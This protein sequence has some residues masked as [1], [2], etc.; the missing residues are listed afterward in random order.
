MLHVDTDIPR[1]DAAVA[2]PSPNLDSPVPR[3]DTVSV[4]NAVTSKLLRVPKQILLATAR[5]KLSVTSGHSVSVRALLDQGSEAT[6]I[7]E[8][9]A[10]LLRAK[11]Q[12]AHI[13][14][15]A[16]GGIQL[17]QVRQATTIAVSPL[18]SDSPSFTVTA[19]I[20]RSLTHYAPRRVT[21]LSEISHLSDLSWADPDPL[22]SDP[23]HVILGADLYGDLILDG[24]R[25]GL[26]GQPVAQ[27]SVFG[28]LISGP[29][30]APLAASD[31]SA[32]LTTHHCMSLAPLEEAIVKFWEVEDLPAARV[33]TQQ[34]EQCE[35]HFCTTHSRTSDGRYIVRLPFNV[36]LPLNLGPTRH[37]AGMQ[38]LQLQ[39]RFDTHPSLRAEYFQ[40]MTEYENL[41]HMRKVR[42]SQG[43]SQRVFIPHHPVIRADSATTRLRVVFNASSRSASGLSLNDFL[44]AGPKLQTELPAI[45]LQWRQ[46]RFVYT[47]D[48]AKMFRQILIDERDLDYQC[49]LW[50]G[51]TS[52]SID[53]YQL[54][55]VTYGMKC[56]PYLALRV[57]RRLAE[58]D[59]NRFPLAASILRRQIYVDDVLFGDHD[60]ASLK[61]KRD[62]LV[63]L[64][65]CGQFT[66]RKWASNSTALLE[67]I[68]P[69]DHGLACDK[70]LATDGTVKILG[71]VWNPNSD[72]FSYRVS[73]DREVSLTKRSVLS[74]IARLYDPLGWATPVIIAAKILM[75][76]LWR[77]QL[78]WDSPLPPHFV[79]RWHP[80][81]TSFQFLNSVHI[82]RWTSFGPSSSL[83][84]H[85]FADASTLAYAAAV[86]ARVT[87][88]DGETR[89]ILLAGKSKVAP[90]K[91]LTVPRLELLAALLLSRLMSFVK[92][93]L[94]LSGVSCF[95]WSDSTITLSWLKSPPLR[96][97]VFAVNRV[98]RI[99]EL[100]PEAVWRHVLT[101]DNP[102]DCASRGILGS[103]ILS[104]SLWWRGPAWL[105]QPPS[106]WPAD[107]QSRES[108]FPE[109]G[110]TVSHLV[111]NQEPP[112]NLASRF[113][114]WDKLLRVT[115]YVYRFTSRCLRRSIVDIDSLSNSF[116]LS[117][118]EITHARN[119][120]IR[121]IQGELFAA[122]LLSLKRKGTVPS[123]SV[124]SA[125]SPFLDSDSVLRVGG[126]LRHAYLSYESK[127]P[128]LLAAHPLVRLLARQYHLRSL[129]G[130][131]Q[132][133][134]RNLRQQFWI[135]RARC[136]VKTE[137]HRCVICVRERSAASTQ[138]MG[139]LPAE[140]VTP[141]PRAFS[142]CGLD[143]AGPVRVRASAGRGNSIKKAYIAVFICLSTRAVHLELVGD[144]STPAFIGAFTRFCSRRGLPQSI[145]SDNGTN[146]VGADKEL[147]A[148][149]RAALRDPNFLNQTASDRVAW[150]F[151]P[152]AAPH[153]GGIWEAGVRSVK[154]HLRRVVGSHTLSNE[155]FVTLL[156]QVEACLNSRPI[157][158]MSDSLEDYQYLTPGH[159]LIGSPLT[160]PPEPS[161]FE[162]KEGRLTR[163]QL[164]RQFAERLWRLWSS[165]YIN[166]LQQRAKWR[167]P[168]PSLEVGQLVFLRNPLLPPCKWEIGR[169]IQVHPGADGLVRVATVKT[170]SSSY[171]RP[172]GKIC[173]LPIRS[174]SD[175]R[176]ASELNDNPAT[177]L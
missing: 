111:I 91:P 54:L 168:E 89:V 166:T 146:F 174:Y 69:L 110:E 169:V 162:L 136:L 164:V 27:R 161:L 85:G 3:S 6:F 94:N 36:A 97:N 8:S 26:S 13:N 93:A 126:R 130:G 116:A 70:N 49:I 78:D 74:I 83:E 31:P 109:V 150:H 95:C 18:Q 64:L 137:I 143:Y 159:F 123:K 101:S 154:H 132:L 90:I 53:E 37:R 1:A 167:K 33:L 15:S 66:L 175:P 48:I 147:T 173:V 32:S 120:W 30:C 160:V 141:P 39:R 77:L 35:E 113:S 99:R 103:T 40:F 118:P 25:H 67:D 148:A 92:S 140:R 152:P 61:L 12:R 114:S 50:R 23:I 158:P 86:Y 55:T 63:S 122:E 177:K 46:F 131:L 112:W 125:Y 121:V 76:S 57:L 16:V 22:S 134:L 51:E 124:L 135:L 45:L 20:L 153:F 151:I 44:H 68:D 47:A 115:A 127:H 156:C 41:R 138:L 87:L 10:Q 157:A 108:D 52:A 43:A 82:P 139:N 4:N 102:A 149:Y 84:L 155:E 29:L 142:W 7:S 128:I 117:V 79:E 105:L 72:G 58:D 96:G 14:I 60:V 104:H 119:Y 73:L 144:Y 75:Q 133:T 2:A 129:H 28:W 170:A 9:M 19:L 88:A 62:Q 176:K 100:L 34:E 71:I 65:K 17:G 80:V 59:G 145:Y 21:S 172:V 42:S 11:R 165:D 171:V 5:V 24:V 81:Y 163:W 107:L 56:A 38:F 106:E 98:S